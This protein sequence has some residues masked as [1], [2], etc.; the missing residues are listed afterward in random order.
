MTLNWDCSCVTETAS[1]QQSLV[2]IGS[3]QWDLFPKSVTYNACVTFEIK[4]EGHAANR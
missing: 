3:V 1:T 2:Q 4:V